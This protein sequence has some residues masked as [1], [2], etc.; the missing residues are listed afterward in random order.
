MTKKIFLF[1]TKDYRQD[2]FGYGSYNHKDR[3]FEQAVRSGAKV[4]ISS[5]N[6]LIVKN[7]KIFI[8]RGILKN[9][10]GESQIKKP[11]SIY[12]TYIN[13]HVNS[14]DESTTIDSFSSEVFDFIVKNKIVE[15]NLVEEG[16]VTNK[17]VLFLIKKIWKKS[18]FSYNSRIAYIG[19]WYLEK[20]LK[21]AE[22]QN[23]FA[24]RPKSMIA[25]ID[26]VHEK[27]K[28]AFEK[29]NEKFIILKA[30]CGTRLQGIEL[31]SREDYLE[32]LD[33]IKDMGDDFFVIQKYISDTF[34]YKDR[35]TDMRIYVGVF[36]WNPL[37]FRVYPYGLT[38]IASKPFDINSFSDANGSITT[39]G[40]L[41]GTLEHNVTIEEY[42]D[43]I[44]E[45]SNEK[46]WKGINHEIEQTLKGILKGGNL[47]TKELKNNIYLL[48]FDVMMVKENDECVPYILEVNHFPTLYRGKENDPDD[49]TNSFLDKSYSQFFKDI[50]Y[51]T[52]HRKLPKSTF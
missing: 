34:M 13:A 3:L 11:I 18:F 33:K 23:I 8:K 17:Y 5:W 32:K 6:N 28:D 49:K 38:R 47:P 42:F 20:Y 27:I 21:A 14:A 1:L 29:E 4:Y 7:K 26:D 15:N 43:S 52:S 30:H 36:S 10:S 46:I 45:H 2:T 41:N 37:V 48:G 40:L 19:K 44:S 25:S 12:P 35:K 31:F 22:D 51:Y 16:T 39:F 9:D 24:S 50:I